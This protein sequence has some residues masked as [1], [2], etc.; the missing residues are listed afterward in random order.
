MKKI[1]IL[2]LLVVLNFI[3]MSIW[4]CIESDG[5][6]DK[7]PDQ[8]TKAWL[9]KENTVYTESLFSEE[10]RQDRIAKEPRYFKMKFLNWN[11]DNLNV[12]ENNNSKILLEAIEDIDLHRVFQYTYWDFSLEDVKHDFSRYVG[13]NIYF[14]KCTFSKMKIVS[15]NSDLA[16]IITN[17][18]RFY[19]IEFTDNKNNEGVLYL[20]SSYGK[21]LLPIYE[22][23]TKNNLLIS[24]WPLGID[25]NGRMVIAI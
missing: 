12:L 5:L 13:E 6:V 8:L 22:G 2:G 10:E 20:L 21:K 25:N 9:V 14:D 24:G 23:R 11:I 3:C 19:I 16:N 17:S 15:D 7:N 4:Y 18:E 1:I